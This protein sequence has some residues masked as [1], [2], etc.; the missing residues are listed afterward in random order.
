MRVFKPSYY[1][2]FKC[3]AGRCKHNCCIGWEIDIDE[4]TMDLYMSE[5]GAFGERL[6]ENISL[7]GDCPHFV[8][9][10]GDR[11]PFL[12]DKNLCDVI[13]NMG[14]ESLCQICSDHPRFINCIEDRE[15]MGIGM[16][17][18]EAA[19]II[20]TYKDK[21]EILGEKSD[22]EEMVFR[23][24]VVPLPDKISI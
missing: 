6:K 22:D 2:D 11:C 16:C 23:L 4:D 18:E 1:D 12:N 13:I 7:E 10:K 14:E 17:C 24:R 21:V 19:R 9:G 8:L 3:I 15:E 20:V 5:H